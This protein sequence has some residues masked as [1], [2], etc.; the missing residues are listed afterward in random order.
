VLDDGTLK[1][2]QVKK[3]D[4]VGLRGPLGNGYPLDEFKGKEILVVGGSIE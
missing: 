4:I 1:K 3:G 2:I